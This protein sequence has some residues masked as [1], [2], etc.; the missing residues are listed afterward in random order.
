MKS[1]FLTLLTILLLHS[2]VFSQVNKQAYKSDLGKQNLFDM[3]VKKGETVS[4]SVTT[5]TIFRTGFRV[6]NGGFLKVR[7]EGNPKN[8]NKE[9][10]EFRDGLVTIKNK[11]DITVN[12]LQNYP[13]PFNP[14]TIIQYNLTANSSVNLTVFDI[15][16][17][18]I[19]NIVNSWQPKGM[20]SVEFDGS[21]L[22]SGV[23]FYRLETSNYVKTMKMIISK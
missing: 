19:K 4:V 7:F 15:L 16:G 20:Y 10:G 11:K 2:V 8:P 21:M 13:N 17:R 18:E 22:S 1:I 5:P 3:V 14:R 9:N 23:Y 12:L 6:E